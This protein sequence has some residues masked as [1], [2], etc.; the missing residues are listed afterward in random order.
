MAENSL[1]RSSLQR[2]MAICAGSEHTGGDIRRK[3]SAWGVTSGDADEIIALLEKENFINDRRYASS[4]TNDRLKYN[5]WG[6]FKIASQLR[7]KGIPDDIIRS[8]LDDI[9]EGQYVGMIKEVLASYR[10]TVKAKNQYDLKGKLMRFGLSRG[11]ENHLM[12]DL[13]ND[14]D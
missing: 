7:M 4:Y 5:K 3:L 13:L 10:K 2:A 9:D 14:L 11:Y 1:F 12:Y 6:K 8:A